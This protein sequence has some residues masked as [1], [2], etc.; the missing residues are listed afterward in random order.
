MMLVTTLL[1]KGS[2]SPRIR[3]AKPPFL[4]II[5]ILWDRE[6]RTAAR[7]QAVIPGASPPLFNM[8]IFLIRTSL[9]RDLLSLSVR[10]VLPGAHSM[11]LVYQVHLSVYL[12]FSF[13]QGQTS[14]L[15]SPRNFAQVQP[16]QSE[17]TCRPPQMPFRPL[18]DRPVQA[19][20]SP[21]G[22]SHLT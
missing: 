3:P 17:L 14:L 16:E 20:C 1:S 4:P 9:G 5:S 13:L 7:I 15:R 2:I 6:I 12:L 10:I 19:V 22:T 21:Y 8:P 11:P 18:P